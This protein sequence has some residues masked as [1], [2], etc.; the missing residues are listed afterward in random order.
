MAG[1]ANIFSDEYVFLIV[2]L[3]V[4]HERNILEKG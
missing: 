3:S 1:S 2:D 4:I